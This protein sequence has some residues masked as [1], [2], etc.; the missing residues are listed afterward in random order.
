MK[1]KNL[2]LSII[3]LLSFGCSNNDDLSKDD[4]AANT[5]VN[6]NQD[7]SLAG[8]QWKLT[9]F[10][11]ASEG[12]IKTPETF[13]HV[14]YNCYWIR[15]NDDNTCR[16]RSSSNLLLGHYSVNSVSSEI[17]ITVGMATYVGELPDGEEF[18]DKLNRVH[19]FVIKDSSLMLY[20][21]E[22]DYLL[23]NIYDSEKE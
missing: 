7:I 23:F 15:F 2:L 19:S 20:H 18:I 12:T 5:E 10:V 9:S 22:T 1:T 8:T 14:P 3:L 17:Q 13:S 11:N 4:N 16:G 6:E 21:N